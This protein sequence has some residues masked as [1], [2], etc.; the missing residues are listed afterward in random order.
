VQQEMPENH[1]TAIWPVVV[2][3]DGN[4]SKPDETD[5]VD[6]NG[7]YG[8]I[9]CF[10]AE[11]LGLYLDRNKFTSVWISEAWFVVVRANEFSMPQKRTCL[12]IYQYFEYITALF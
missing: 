4:I 8:S 7:S 1:H 2:T 11:I 5:F 3:V 12:N 6:R 9:M 10:H